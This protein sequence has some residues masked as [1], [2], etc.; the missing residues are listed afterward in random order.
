[1]GSS[2]WCVWLRVGEGV[3]I[4]FLF[5]SVCPKSMWMGMAT[6]HSSI[7]GLSSMAAFLLLMLVESFLF[8]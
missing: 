3:G 4:T 1:M 5:G 8:S 2:F 7:H 6:F